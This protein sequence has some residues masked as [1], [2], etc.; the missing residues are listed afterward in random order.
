MLLL[1]MLAAAQLIGT[2][3]NQSARRDNMT[4]NLLTKN[5]KP[6]Y[7]WFEAETKRGYGEVWI[8]LKDLPKFRQSLID[9]RDK[10]VEWTKVADENNV[11]NL[12][13]EIPV[14]FPKPIYWWEI[15]GERFYDDYSGWKMIFSATD[16]YRFAF[17]I[18][19]AKD[20]QNRFITENYRITFSC[21]KDFDSLIT[22]LD[23]DKVKAVEG[24]PKDENLFK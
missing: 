4:V 22:M 17:M 16:N 6:M 8:K 11:K 15:G 18:V 5:N 9:A 23:P 2:F 10:Y 14:K 19:E 20:M 12:R 21:V 3:S 1:P 7:V 13:K 24:N